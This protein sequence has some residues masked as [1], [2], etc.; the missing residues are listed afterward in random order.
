[1]S[2]PGSSAVLREPPAIDSENKC[3]IPRRSSTP[4]GN[5]KTNS[6]ACPSI[7][8]DCPCVCPVDRTLDLGS[9]ENAPILRGFS[10]ARQAVASKNPLRDY[11]GYQGRKVMQRTRFTIRSAPCWSPSTSLTRLSPGGAHRQRSRGCRRVPPPVR[12]LGATANRGSVFHL[13]PCVLRGESDR[14]SRGHGSV[15]PSS[16]STV[17][18]DLLSADTFDKAVSLYSIRIETVLFSLEK[19]RLRRGYLRSFLGCNPIVFR[20]VR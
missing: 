12:R 9:V 10:A 17:P 1:M 13:A 6:G 3:L 16:A 18:L 19:D 20:L 11:R 7:V 4:R 5:L 14:I 15:R 2:Q 8:M